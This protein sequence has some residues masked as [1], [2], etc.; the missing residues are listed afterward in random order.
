MTFVFGGEKEITW[1]RAVEVWLLMGLGF[2]LVLFLFY[3]MFEVP[4]IAIGNFLVKATFKEKSQTL[5]EPLS[6]SKRLQKKANS[7]PK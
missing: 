2:S 3:Y 4:S 5:G 7:M 6:A 1:L